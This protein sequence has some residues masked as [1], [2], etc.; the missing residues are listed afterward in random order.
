[1]GRIAPEGTEEPLEAS[2]N[3]CLQKIYLARPTANFDKG[4]AKT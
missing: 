2:G 1:L 3:F 4:P